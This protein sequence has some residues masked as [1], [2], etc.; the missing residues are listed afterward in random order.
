LADGPG[1]NYLRE[2]CSSGTP[3]ILCRFRHQALDDSDKILWSGTAG[4]GLFNR[5]GYEDRVALG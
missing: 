5:L 2:A 3:Y 4:I 1:R